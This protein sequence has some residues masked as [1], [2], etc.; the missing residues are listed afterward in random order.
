M[1]K[2]EIFSYESL[3]ESGFFNERIDFMIISSP[4]DP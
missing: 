3:H 1:G 4:T 2:F